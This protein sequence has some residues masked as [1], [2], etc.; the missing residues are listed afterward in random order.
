MTE[1][2]VKPVKWA[3]LTLIILLVVVLGVWQGSD[4]L[5]FQF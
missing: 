2:L 5:Y 1:K 3:V 4:F